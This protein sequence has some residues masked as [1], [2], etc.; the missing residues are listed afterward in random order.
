M[1][2][3]ITGN[4]PAERLLSTAKQVK[5]DL[6]MRGKRETDGGVVVN[7]SAGV[8][9]ALNKAIEDMEAQP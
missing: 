6:L 3:P 8:W 4:T 2:P 1:R 5:H 9:I 7:L